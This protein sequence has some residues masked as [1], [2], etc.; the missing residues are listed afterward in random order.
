[1]TLF[2]ILVLLYLLLIVT[3]DV[4]A[5]G[6]NTAV[7][8]VLGG[9][10]AEDLPRTLYRKVLRIQSAKRTARNVIRVLQIAV[11]IPIAAAVVV[12]IGIVIIN[13]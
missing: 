7:A 10:D 11:L 9:K 8:R 12:A 2:N 13:F 1:M 6:F 3:A 5:W 4:A